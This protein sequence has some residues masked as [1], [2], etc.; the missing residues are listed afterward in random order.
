MPENRD[1]ILLENL[2]MDVG[3][4]EKLEGMIAG[5][6]LFEAIGMR[7]QEIKHSATLAFLLNP[8]KPHGLGDYFLRRFLKG[9]TRH[10]D[11]EISPIS[12]DC[13]DLSDAEVWCER[14]HIDILIVCKSAELVIAIENKIYARES[15]GQLETYDTYV[16]SNDEWDGYAKLFVFLTINGDKAVGGSEDVKWASYAHG[17]VTEVLEA[18]L[19]ANKTNIGVDQE[20]LIRH[21]LELMRRHIL[22][23]SDIAKLAGDIYKKHKQALDLIFQHIPNVRSEASGHLN[24]LIS[25][26]PELV[27]VHSTNSVFRFRHK[28]WSFRKE[29]CGE[30]KAFRDFGVV[31]EIPYRDLPEKLTIEL[32]VGNISS[33][34]KRHAL[35]DEI[36]SKTIYT[37][38]IM[39]SNYP[40]A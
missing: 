37:G 28:D 39:D 20:V 23:D 14:K 7:S 8:N 2:V 13:A 4:L 26:V 36:A 17:N 31:Y 27:K 38:N 12:I 6:N 40:R 1:K 25:Q 15:E 30:A 24:T 33:A 10:S 32:V 21:Y 29:W 34:E 16:N 9:I 22:P 18:S 19:Q 3:G 35:R 5:F 11:T